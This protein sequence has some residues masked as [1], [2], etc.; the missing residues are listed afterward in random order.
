[1]GGPALEH[2]QSATPANFP[3]GEITKI[4]PS[5]GAAQIIHSK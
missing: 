5:L 2:T 1:M 3:Q 4:S